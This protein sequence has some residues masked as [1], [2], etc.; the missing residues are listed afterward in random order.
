M[1]SSHTWKLYVKYHKCP[2]CGYIIESRDD[3]RYEMG[4]YLKDLECLRC[5][6][7]FVEMKDPPPRMAPL[8][9]EAEHVEWD[10]E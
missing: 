6:H 3:Y 1:P 5:K 9:G 2:K 7:H 8:L 4:K 10:W